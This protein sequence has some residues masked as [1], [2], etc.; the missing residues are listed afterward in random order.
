M[1]DRIIT[2]A[3]STPRADKL[4][5]R[6]MALWLAMIAARIVGQLLGGM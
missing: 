3:I 2:L 1:I 4:A 6:I 5:T